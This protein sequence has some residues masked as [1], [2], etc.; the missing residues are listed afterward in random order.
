MI[1][2]IDRGT[3]NSYGNIIKEVKQRATSFNCIFSFEG[4]AANVDADR[5]AK[6]SNSRAGA[7]LVV[8]SP[9]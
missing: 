4:R 7:P 9:P 3:G 1:N 2:D 8:G 6:F 5:L